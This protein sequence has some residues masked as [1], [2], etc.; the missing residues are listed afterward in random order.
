[1]LAVAAPAHAQVVA[2]EQ[3]SVDWTP[4]FAD[5]FA[6]GVFTSGPGEPYNVACGTANEAN[7]RLAVATSSACTGFEIRPLAL[8]PDGFVLRALISLPTTAEPSVGTPNP[9]RI[10]PT[11]QAR[12]G[13]AVR[14]A[15]GTDALFLHVRRSNDPAQECADIPSPDT[16]FGTGG[17]DVLYI[18]LVDESG[19]TISRTYT[20]TQNPTSSPD[21]PNAY[22]LELELVPSDGLLLPTARFREC[23]TSYLAGGPCAPAD[24]LVEL[25]TVTGP[26]ADVS[27]D[28]GALEAGVVHIP[29]FYANA[30][31]G[32]FAVRIDDWDLEMSA[33]DDFATPPLGAT[34]PYQ[35][36]TAVCGTADVAGGALGLAATGDCPKV[37]AAV[38]GSLASETTAAATLRYELPQRCEERGVAFTAA[39][40]HANLALVRDADGSLGVWLTGGSESEAGPAVALV[41]RATLSATPDGDVTLAATEAIELRLDLAIDGLGG[42]VPHGQYRLC[43]TSPCAEEIPFVDLAVASLDPPAPGNEC[44]DL[45]LTIDGGVVPADVPVAASLYVAPEPHSFASA[46]TAIA[47]LA[48]QRRACAL[49]IRRSRAP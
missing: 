35:T 3:W 45:G 22:E 49:R 7:G 21:L 29:A 34:L 16:C 42:S 24:P 32:A 8:V 37:I 17:N 5:D 28:A 43:P 1:M 48:A 44:F 41:E 4:G 11:T 39:D 47:L 12:V 19:D 14:N 33:A 38:S 25:T 9:P 15:T 20:L 30:P 13:L 26:P 46:L 18:E 40:E 31:G 23:K 2:F 10:A 27:P 36:S 6:D